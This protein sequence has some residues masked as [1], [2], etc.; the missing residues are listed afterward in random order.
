VLP[1]SSHHHEIE[2]D[3]QRTEQAQFGKLVADPADA[4]LAKLSTGIAPITEV[5]L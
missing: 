5:R 2:A 1:D 4:Q 3:R